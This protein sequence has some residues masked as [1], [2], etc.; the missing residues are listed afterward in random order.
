MKKSSGFSLLGNFLD[1][2]GRELMDWGLLCGTGWAHTAYH[3]KEKAELKSKASDLSVCFLNLI[4]ENVDYESKKKMESSDWYGLS[5]PGYWT[6]NWRQNEKS[7][8][9]IGP[10]HHKN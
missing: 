7:Y 5:P 3:V 9:T 6:E 4:W 2:E 8:L 1:V 10:S